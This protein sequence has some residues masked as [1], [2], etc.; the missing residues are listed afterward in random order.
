MQLR[1]NLLRP[2]ILA[3]IGLVILDCVG[4]GRARVMLMMVA[5]GLHCSLLSFI[6]K[7]TLSEGKPLVTADLN[8][9]IRSIRSRVVRHALLLW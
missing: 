8:G 9:A 4:T 6:K 3:A 1:M 2:R 5:N 7:R